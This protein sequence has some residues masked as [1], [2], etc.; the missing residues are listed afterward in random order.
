MKRSMRFKIVMGFCLI[1]LVSITVS[2]AKHPMQ[3]TLSV[4][5]A[6]QKTISRLVEEFEKVNPDIKVNLL[7]LPAVSSQQYER[8]VPT[9]MARD[10][11]I[12]VLYM[13]IIWPGV[14]ATN[15]WLEPLGKYFTPEMQKEF[16][17]GTVNANRVKGEIYGA[18][19][20]TDG[21]LL[22]YRKDLLEKY[23]FEPPKTWNE[24]IEQSQY[25]L[26]QEKNPELRGFIFQG[27]RIEGVTCNFLEY[28]WGMGGDVLDANGKVIIDNEKGKEALQFMYDLIYKHKISPAA[29]ST[30]VPDESRIMFLQGKAIFMRNWTFA[31]T[32]L[33]DDQSVVKG[34]VDVA[35][36]PHKEGFQS[37]S[38]LGGWNLGISRFSKKK[39][40]AWRLVEFLTNFE[41]QKQLAMYEA[42]LPTRHAVYNDPEVLEKN[43]W[44][45]SLHIGLTAG[46]PRPL[47]PQYVAMSGVIQQEVNAVLSKMKTPDE[48][49]KTIGEKLRSIVK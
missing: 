46:H 41:S 38:T 12:D 2:A 43:S 49:I 3:I 6:Q 11:S 48:G 44:F 4:G 47:H 28:L 40:Q 1:L 21:G 45:A 27:A 20:F 32:S 34:K 31:W 8:L 22:F 26:E 13:D 16:L 14:F 19:L 9:F 10:S 5:S 36:I 35:A 17:E 29:V 25:I 7:V 30:Q 33:Q 15:K 24:L 18:P 23:G 42:T 39:A 37:A